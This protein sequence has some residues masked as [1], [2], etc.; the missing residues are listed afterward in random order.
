M[1]KKD[2]IIYDQNRLIAYQRNEILKL[3]SNLNKL[4]DGNFEFDLEM[5]EGDEITR[6]DREHFCSLNIHLLKVKESIDV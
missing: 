1:L 6:T 5:P 4:A 3:E 2:R